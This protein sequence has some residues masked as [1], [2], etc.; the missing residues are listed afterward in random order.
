MTDAITRE[1]FPSAN[2]ENY[3]TL[4]FR[5][6]LRTFEGG[7]HYVDTPFGAAKIAGIGNAFAQVDNLEAALTTAEQR[8]AT[9]EKALEFY[10]KQHR[11]P[12]EGPWGINS[13]DFGNV[14]RAALKG[15][16]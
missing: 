11:N 4:V 9:L 15:K 1:D 2:D 13:S 3:C 7:P 16:E 14:A 8:I 12:N 10:A 5:C 6:S